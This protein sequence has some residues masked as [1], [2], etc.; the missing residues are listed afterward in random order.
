LDVAIEG[1][2]LDLDY[3][4][5]HDCIQFNKDPS[6]MEIKLTDVVLRLSLDA[7]EV[8]SRGAAAIV[9]GLEEVLQE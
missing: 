1:I 2:Q 9:R 6:K 3:L 5:A 4:M 8:L 7:N